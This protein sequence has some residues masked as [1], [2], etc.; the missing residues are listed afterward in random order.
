MGV[1]KQEEEKYKIVWQERE[2]LKE[3]EKK[4]KKAKTIGCIYLRSKKLKEAI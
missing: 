2:A 3:K 4:K 1:P